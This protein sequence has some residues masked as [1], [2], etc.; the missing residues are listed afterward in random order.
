MTK[1]SK[2]PS[3][4]KSSMSSSSAMSITLTNL[5]FTFPN[6]LIFKAVN[7]SLPKNKITL[8]SG[9]NGSGKTTLC[10]LLSKLETDFTGN[11]ETPQKLLYL[12]QSAENNLLA[13]TPIQDLKV[14]THSKFIP[15]KSGQNSKL[16]NFFGLTDQANQPIWELSGGQQQ[17]VA[18]SA[19]LLHPDHFWLLDEPA[20]GLDD[21]QQQNLL[22][23]L[24]GHQHG[25]LI[26]THR[27][28]LFAPVTDQNYV[29][30]NYNIMQTLTRNK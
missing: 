18:L 30:K 9:A 1:P 27:K 29:I 7:L 16:L 17:R 28:E 12:K 8:L 22:K 6:N 20:A 21:Q 13:A 23:L 26:I 2:T 10:R 24:K 5:S 25:A 4:S 19:L 3:S 14:W 11:I 15:I